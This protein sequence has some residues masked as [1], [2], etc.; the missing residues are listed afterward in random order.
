ML[1]V[2]M[3]IYVDRKVWAAM[4]LRS[5]FRGGSR[6]ETY[7]FWIDGEAFHLR[8]EGESVEVRQGSAEAPEV[9]LSGRSGVFLAL[10][11]GRLAPEEALEKGEIRVESGDEAL[12]RCLGRL[13]EARV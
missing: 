8:A 10:A 1:A 11:A 12:G 9:V 2:A 3:I 5:L 4:A 13:A 6:R 7:E